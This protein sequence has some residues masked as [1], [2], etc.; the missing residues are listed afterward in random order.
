MKKILFISI[1]TIFLSGC[2]N[3]VYRPP[4]LRVVN[5]E[6]YEWDYHKS[7][8]L[9]LVSAIYDDHRMR[10]SDRPKGQAFSETAAGRNTIDALNF[11]AFGFTGLLLSSGGGKDWYRSEYI[12]L[13]EKESELPS[14]SYHEVIKDFV[15]KLDTSLNGTDKLRVKT[16]NI[17]NMLYDHN[18][19]TS[20][21]FEGEL[22]EASTVA[23]DGA[24]RNQ[25]LAEKVWVGPKELSGTVCGM[26]THVG[27]IHPIKKDGKEYW[28]YH[29]HVN[30]IDQII[31]KELFNRAPYFD[32]Y[33]AFPVKWITLDN[34]KPSF[35]VVFEGTKAHYFIKPE[36]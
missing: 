1:L 22:C 27:E 17:Y 6:V 16:F 31:R 3:T 36:A 25:K 20:V 10:D 29:I 30:G 21:Y 5:N 4:Q 26:S 13:E 24:M 19:A 15:Q 28:V 7:T 32:G 2:I 8:A 12:W 9:N 11:A 34:G 14:K 33:V 23:F 18:D 35:P